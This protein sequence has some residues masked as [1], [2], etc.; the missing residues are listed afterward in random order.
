MLRIDLH[1]HTTA[2]D[3]TLTPR[4]LVA[5]AKA[6][7]VDVIAVTDHDTVA[8]I[9]EVTAVAKSVNIRVVTGIEITA[10]DDGRDVHMLGYGFDPSS[11]KLLE[12]LEAQH[13]RAGLRTDE[14]NRIRRRGGGRVHRDLRDAQHSSRSRQRRDRREGVGVGS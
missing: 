5:R 7:N 14:I 8:A 12:F 3:G 2:S 13:G 1:C 6:D 4:E 10:V 9:A 11:S